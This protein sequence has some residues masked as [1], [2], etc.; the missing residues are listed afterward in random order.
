MPRGSQRRRRS[1]AHPDVPG[2]SRDGSL[3]P[4]EYAAAVCRSKI[5]Y[6]TEPLA[7]NA[8][9]LL[10]LAHP[11]YWPLE[12]YQCPVCDVWHLR[13]VKPAGAR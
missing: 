11:Q 6:L 9:Y 3:S 1:G 13:T 10:A 5:D 12:P 8:A 2:P 4:E 7:A